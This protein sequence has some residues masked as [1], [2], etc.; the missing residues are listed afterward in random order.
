MNVYK[1]FIT[2]IILIFAVNALD[3]QYVVDLH[4]V[5]YNGLPENHFNEYNNLSVH[6]LNYT[7]DLNLPISQKNNDVLMIGGNLDRLMAYTDDE[8]LK[9]SFYLES[10]VAFRFRFDDSQQP[11]P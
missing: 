9:N 5:N 1:I 10:G 3:A 11:K 7:N 2:G 4:D 6:F 8:N